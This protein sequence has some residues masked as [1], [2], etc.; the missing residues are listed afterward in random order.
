[1]ESDDNR[2]PE[3]QRGYEEPERV[4][5]GPLDVGSPGTDRLKKKSGCGLIMLVG[6]SGLVGASVGLYEAAQYLF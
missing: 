2:W 4:D 1:M 6:G 3:H 5:I